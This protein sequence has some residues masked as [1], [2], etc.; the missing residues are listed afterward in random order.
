MIKRL[1][2]YVRGVYI[3][4]FN[5]GVSLSRKATV[6][7]SKLDSFAHMGD[8]AFIYESKLGCYTSIGRNSVIRNSILG[9]FC[10]I[11]WG[12]TI[13]A[14]PHNYDLISTHAFH[15]IRSFGF[16][17]QD[18]RITLQTKIGNDVWVGANAIIMPGLVVGDGAVIGAG[19]VVT[20]DVPS[21]AIVAG[22]PA[23]IIKFRFDENVTSKL[24]ELEWWHWPKS[25]IMANMGLF[26][27]SVTIDSL[28]DIK[29]G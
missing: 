11:S 10:S 28:S 29:D 20:K 19:A 6:I 8:Y 13:G 22:V 2:R 14:T 5:D 18:K 9:K 3:R 12:V 27:T 7:E 1:Y 24:V 15:Y 26:N 17:D 25:K 21:Y 16:V 4:S 23:K